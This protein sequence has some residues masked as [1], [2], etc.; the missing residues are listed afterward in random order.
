MNRV[1]HPIISKGL[2]PWV[3]G[4]LAVTMLFIRSSPQLMAATLDITG[5]MTTEIAGPASSVTGPGAGTGAF[6]NATNY[7]LNYGGATRTL[8]H[9]NTGYGATTLE[10]EPLP[11]GGVIDVVLRRNSVGQT[12][13]IVWTKVNSTVGTVY[14][15]AA[16]QQTSEGGAFSKNNFYQ[17]ADNVFTNAADGNGNNNNV[18]RLDVIFRSG[19]VC[20]ADLT[21][22]IWERGVSNAHDAFKIAAITAVDPVTGLP[23]A[24]GAVI[25]IAAGWGATDLN[26]TLGSADFT[27]VVVRNTTAGGGAIS[28][29]ALTTNNQSVGGISVSVTSAAAALGLGINTG[30]T[31]Y[32]YSLFASDVSNVS[33]N[34]VDWNNAANFPTNTTSGGIDLVAFT[35]QVF[36]SVPVTTPVVPEPSTALLSLAAAFVLLKRNR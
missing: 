20:T 1:Q 16:A 36:H 5:L 2:G 14:N 9:Y 19:L 22:A 12:N 27:T 28:P 7:T 13:N 17:G 31:I 3:L 25:N 35:G 23:S 18:E 8:N 32:G 21:F 30:S 4:A 15:L 10:Y 24:Y 26:S 29:S 6:S 11:Y 34:V 33:A